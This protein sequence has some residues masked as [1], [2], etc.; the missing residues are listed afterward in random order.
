M[1][2][3]EESFAVPRASVVS[4]A[5]DEA[6]VEREREGIAVPVPERGG[7]VELAP[8]EAGPRAGLRVEVRSE[9]AVGEVLRTERPLSL[10]GGEVEASAPLDGTVRTELRA[11]VVDVERSLRETGPDREGLDGDLGGHDVAAV[12]G[13]VG[14]GMRDAPP[15]GGREREC[16][17]RAELRSDRLRRQADFGAERQRRVGREAAGAGGRRGKAVAR[18]VE[19]LEVDRPGRR[20]RERDLSRRPKPEGAGAIDDDGREVAT[21][22]QCAGAKASGQP[23]PLDARSEQDLPE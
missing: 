21:Q 17:P 16:S 8:R 19:L 2:P 11:G 7:G 3:R 22:P 14:L 9:E 15:D 13:Q 1:R 5:K 23:G 4:A 6:G 20:Q 12:D 10:A 18:E